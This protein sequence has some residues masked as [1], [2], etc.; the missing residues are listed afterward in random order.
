VLITAISIN[1][2]VV[3][4]LVVFTRFFRV[5]FNSALTV[6]VAVGVVLGAMAARANL[7][8]VWRFT[9]KICR[10]FF[11]SAYN[12]GVILQDLAE[13]TRT[14]SGR[15]ELANLLE[16]QIEEALHPKSLA[17]YLERGDGNLAVETRPQL[18]EG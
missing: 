5:P 3:L 4:F 11:R 1:A 2:V 6:G 9:E 7:F 12:A 14:V 18:E 8:I 10:A 16:V 17:C 15:Q 13:K